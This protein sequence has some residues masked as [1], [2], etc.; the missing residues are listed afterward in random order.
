VVIVALGTRG[1]VTVPVAPEER[2]DP[3]GEGGEGGEVSDDGGSPV[4]GLVVGGSEDGSWDA[5]QATGVKR[6]AAVRCIRRA[7]TDSASSSYSVVSSKAA[8]RTSRPA[9]NS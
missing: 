3:E 5:A 7:S 4:G 6:V 8:I 1:A 9:A 2:G